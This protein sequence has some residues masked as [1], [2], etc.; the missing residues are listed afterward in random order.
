MK[1]VFTQ[2]KNISFN[3]YNSNLNGQTIKVLIVSAVVI[4][5][6]LNCTLMANMKR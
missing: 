2:N 5:V 3:D 6:K 1:R 4:I